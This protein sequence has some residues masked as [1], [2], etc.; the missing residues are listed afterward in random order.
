MR[1]R[2]LLRRGCAIGAIGLAGC[3]GQGEGPSAGNGGTGGT[4]TPD[5]G[6]VTGVNIETLD[7]DCAN[8][9]QPTADVQFDESSGTI[10]I[11]G[12]LRT[13]NPCRLATV[14]SVEFDGGSDVLSVKLGTERDGQDGC[15]QCL[16]MVE[17]EATLTVEGDLPATVAVSAVDTEQLARVDRETETPTPDEPPTVQETAFTV[18]GRS[19]TS[20]GSTA[21]VTFDDEEQR[22][23]ATGTIIGNDGCQTASLGTVEYDADEDQVGIDVVTEPR[24]G[25]DDE[26]CTQ[27]QVAITYEA[28]V[29]F[30]GGTPRS[31]SVSHDGDGVVSAAH[32][33]ATASAPA[34]SEDE[35]SGDTPSDA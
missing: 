5:V 19:N 22:V 8:G 10:R 20:G 26:M 27:A 13:A 32:G 6:P 14:E 7:S 21:D 4:P 15:V 30:A 1:R 34:P 3:L 25:T 16:G 12:I 23:V 17:F 24:P 31:A 18:T 35:A 33:S 28:T 9:E 29:S 11:G 2:T